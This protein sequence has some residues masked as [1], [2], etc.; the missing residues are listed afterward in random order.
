MFYTNRAVSVKKTKINPRGC[1]HPS[2]PGVS[3]MAPSPRWSHC[4][5]SGHPCL[6][7]AAKV[8][9]LE[10]CSAH[11]SFI[12]GKL[13]RA[14]GFMWS[15]KFAFHS[16]AESNTFQV[17]QEKRSCVDIRWSAQ[18]TCL[19]KRCL[20]VRQVLRRPRKSQLWCVMFP[21]DLIKVI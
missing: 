12:N 18:K 1:R 19:V 3:S 15:K 5:S 9:L 20:N 2:F 14:V 13:R 16:R 21:N 7:G 10:L 6:S 11:P 17:G 8:L 4:P